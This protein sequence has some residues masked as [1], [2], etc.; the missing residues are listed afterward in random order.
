[1]ALRRGRLDPDRLPDILAELSLLPVDVDNAGARDAW[2]EPLA[3]ALAT[4]LTLY[5]ALYVELARRHGRPL[6]T[7]DAAL[8]RAAI[9]AGIAVLP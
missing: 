1:M 9:V 7:F 4:G 6:A 8:R 2:G 3:Q 5:D